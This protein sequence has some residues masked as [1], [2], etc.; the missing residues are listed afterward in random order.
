MTSSKNHGYTTSSRDEPSVPEPSYAERVRTLVYRNRMGTLSTLSEKHPGWPFGSL[1]PYGLDEKGRPIFL[2]S[3]MAMHT[4]NIERDRR[5]SLFVSQ[6]DSLGDPLDASRVTLIGET[7]KVPENEI[8]AVR[9]LYLSRYRNASYWVDF[10]DFFFYRMDI[11]DIYF[12]GGFG[13]MGWVTSEDY[14]KAEVDPL[15]DAASGI[16][17]HMNEDHEDSM[18]LLA[19]KFAGITAGKA[20]MTSVDRLGFQV[21]LKSG[22]EVFSRRIGFPRE[23]INPEDTREVLV[24]MVKEA[25]L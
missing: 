22:D 11:E 3:T 23:V 20:A 6:T 18:I 4:H 13:A 12:V 1:M 19:E 15:A 5:V 2:I 7:S 10:D 9:E 24:Q 17:R 14:F 25:R 21:R 16:I 8:G